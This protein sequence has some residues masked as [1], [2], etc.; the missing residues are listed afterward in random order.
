MH[1]ILAQPRARCPDQG[2]RRAC[3]TRSRSSVSPAHDA[4]FPR[5]RPLRKTLPASWEF[6]Q[7]K[8]ESAGVGEGLRVAADVGI[9]IHPAIV[10]FYR[11]RREEDAGD[12]VIVA[13][14]VVVQAGDRVVVLAGV[15]FVGIGAGCACREA[16]GAVGR[17]ELRTE[18]RGAAAHA[19]EDRHHAAQVVGEEVVGRGRAVAGLASGGGDSGLITCGRVVD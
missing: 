10:A 12:G 2:V 9:G 6:S 7:T 11:I 8:D 3:P 16:R 13:G 19:V 4:L 1:A 18:E 5:V 15:A 14:V 17:V